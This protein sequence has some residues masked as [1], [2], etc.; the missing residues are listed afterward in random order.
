MIS[1][2]RGTVIEKTLTQVVLDVNGV[3]FACGISSTTAAALPAPGSGEE[4]LVHTYL[5]VREDAMTLFGFATAQERSAFEHLI[6]V[7]GVGPKAALSILSVLDPSQLALALA[8]GDYKTLTQAQGV[9]PKVAQ[10]IVLELKDKMAKS[11]ENGSLPKSGAAA[12]ASPSGAATSV[13]DAINALVMLGY[14]Q[15]EAAHSVAGLDPALPTETLLKQALK[16][17][18]G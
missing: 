17:L 9:G 5:Q 16:R 8:S 3:G 15:A 12:A 10:R 7:S 1:F 11:M 4:V 13:S 2:L 6:A 14:S 18:A